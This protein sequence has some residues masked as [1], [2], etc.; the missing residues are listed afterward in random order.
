MHGQLSLPRIAVTCA[1]AMALAVFGGEDAQ[2]QA[3]PAAPRAQILDVFFGLD[4]ALPFRANLLCGGSRVAGMDGVPVTFSRRIA[5]DNPDPTAFRI[6]TQSGA[7]YTPRCATLRP[8]LGANKRHTVLLIGELGS[9]RDPPVRMDVVRSVPL[10]NGG[11]AMGLSSD[12]VTALALGPELR[13]GYRYAPGELPNASCPN[14][15]LQIVQIT[16]AGG[17]TAPGGAEL[18]EAARMGM[19][20]TL[21][22][23]VQVA[24]IALA[25]L[26]DNDNYT[27]LCLDTQTPAERVTVEPGVAID[28]RGDLNPRTSIRITADPE[29][30]R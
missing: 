10:L 13:I 25:D 8:A 19:R 21:S 15:T 5:V 24:P 26:G 20:V 2:G 1:V 6:T 7:V 12:R 27:H 4:D 3:E 14:S 22:N 11:D 9:E 16:W 23:G 28:P 29:A 17:V 18:G 30:L